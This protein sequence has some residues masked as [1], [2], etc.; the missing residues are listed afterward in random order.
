MALLLLFVVWVTWGLSYPITAFALQGFD[1]MTTRSLAQILGC[2][3]L[4]LHALW[5]RQ[6]LTVEREAWGDLVIAGLLNM[7]A[8]P[9][10]FT[11]GIKLLGPGR[12]AILIYTM[13]IWA[14]LFARII[15]GEPLT[16]QRIAALF[17]GTV[18]VVFMVSE[19]ISRIKGA[20]LGAALTLLAALSYGLGT[21][22]F[23]RRRWRAPLA[24]V[25]FWQLA[26]GLVPLFPIWALWSFPPDLTR[27]SAGEWGALL[28]MG[29][30]SN[31]VAYLAWFAVVDRLTAGISAVGSLAIPCL[32][33]AFSAVLS[34]E[35]LYPQDFAAM[36]M[37]GAALILVLVE[38]VGA[39]R[40][41]PALLAP[42]NEEPL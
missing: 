14:N 19:D 37:I 21:V 38:R 23:K 35:R 8:L 25:T 26:I 30:F 13:P 10:F 40:R 29:I 33:I 5:R 18:A 4:L 41:A 42:S 3:A 36:A 17:L 9:I 34:N 11:F 32:A 27:A 39:A 20:P 31:A 7:A 12:T 24:A 6:R 28:Y 16:W 15:L 1:V 22:W 2:V